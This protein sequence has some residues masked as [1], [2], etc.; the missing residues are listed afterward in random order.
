MKKQ[1]VLKAIGKNKW[2]EFIK[3]MD[4]QTLGINPDGS[5]DYYDHDVK[6]FLLLKSLPPKKRAKLEQLIWE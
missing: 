6:K 5:T 2:K 1:E 3:Y 4:G